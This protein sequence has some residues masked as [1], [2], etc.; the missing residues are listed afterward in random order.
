MGV[1][2]LTG[3]WYVDAK[4]GNDLNPG[5]TPT[6]PFKTIAQAESVAQPS[7]TFIIGSG[8]YV[9]VNGTNG[10]FNYRGEGTVLLV[11]TGLVSGTAMG[12]NM[13][14]C[15][16]I[17]FFDYGGGAFA[18]TFHPQNTIQK[19]VGCRFYYCDINN[20]QYS[21]DHIRN[22]DF[23]QCTFLPGAGTQPE[24]NFITQCNF[25]SCSGLFTILQNVNYG[26]FNSIFSDCNALFMGIQPAIPDNAKF[27]YNNVEGFLQGLNQSQL[28]DEGANLNGSNQLISNIYTDYGARPKAVW[29]KENL[30]QKTTSPVLTIGRGGAH[31]GN[32]F[33]AVT[34]T[35][36]NLWN[37]FQSSETDLQLN[38]DVIQVL[39][40][41]TT[42]NFVSTEFDLG[43]EFPLGMF[44]VKSLQ[45]YDLGGATVGYLYYLDDPIPNP[46][47][48]Q[49][50]THNVGINIATTPSGPVSY[51][52]YEPDWDL[53]TDWKGNPTADA[54]EYNA[55]R[56]NEQSGR[57]LTFEFNIVDQATELRSLNFAY[58]PTYFTVCLEDV[59]GHAISSQVN[60]KLNLSNGE[61]IE[62]TTSASEP[63]KIYVNEELVTSIEFFSDACFLGKVE[64]IPIDYY[65]N[66]PTVKVVLEYNES[67]RDTPDNRFHFL[68]FHR[69][70][71]LDYPFTGVPVKSSEKAKVCAECEAIPERIPNAYKKIGC[72]TYYPIVTDCETTAFYINTETPLDFATG[73]L[74]LDIVDQTFTAVE[75]D[76]ATVVKHVVNIDGDYTLYAQD[77]KPENLSDKGIYRFVI[78]DTD[79][80]EVVYIGNEFTHWKTGVTNESINCESTYVEWYDTGDIWGFKYSEL[81]EFK[82]QIRLNLT[83]REIQPETE[84]EQYR[85]D[86]NG[87]RRNLKSET[88]QY[89]VLETYYFDQEAHE[90]MTAFSTHGDVFINKKKYVLKTAYA[91]ETQDPRD[92]SKGTLEM[93]EDD[94]S[95]INKNC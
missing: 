46:V 57:Y 11:G 89:L 52:A 28:N 32:D 14:S 71:G 42:G 50:T 69:A 75:T 29:W 66:N 4:Y 40:P 21:F 25:I 61:G 83:R 95:G 9:H 84:F 38:G 56:Q 13:E 60:Y 54:T 26:I 36:P 17:I 2:K 41:A 15:E 90:G 22:C 82:N 47:I 65:I 33:K 73:T 76:V 62:I 80:D 8:T 55:D 53:Y 74:Q 92:L 7:D 93:Y 87:K 94:F 35:A 85:A 91:V 64:I 24:Y 70:Y 27:D 39:P 67:Y 68:R 10:S 72:E 86:S 5:N 16:N 18:T 34:L 45:A 43:E 77:I 81:P 48:N 6:S 23:V 49:K 58:Q 30:T 20:S 51:D 78:W 12:T 19:Y 79:S 31:M 1:F 37:N 3:E 59:F 44:R 88:D 63:D